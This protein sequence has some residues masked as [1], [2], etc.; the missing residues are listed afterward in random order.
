MK[1]DNAED[2]Q[3]GDDTVM[4]VFNKNGTVVAPVIVA[5]PKRKGAAVAGAPDDDAVSCRSSSTGKSSYEST[6]SLNDEGEPKCSAEVSLSRTRSAARSTV[7]SLRAKCV[8]LKTCGYQVLKVFSAKWGES[9]L[10]VTTLN[11]V[12]KTEAHE[13]ALKAVED[14]VKNVDGWSEKTYQ[15]NHEALMEKVKV[16][17]TADETAQ[18]AANTLKNNWNKNVKESTGDACRLALKIRQTLKTR[19]LLPQGCP[20]TIVS[21]IGESV[22]GVTAD[23][24][25]LAPKTSP[26]VVQMN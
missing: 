25:G 26:L 16:F 4:K 21:W 5:T 3:L 23:A 14:L 2:W 11:C 22:L 7:K 18:T 13:A 6:Q 9:H 19:P 10:E 15:A 1:G 17:R 8:N 24:E 20:P 12:G